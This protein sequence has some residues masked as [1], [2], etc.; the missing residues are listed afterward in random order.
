MSNIEQQ[1]LNILREL[2]QQ[3]DTYDNR[4]GE[5]TFKL[6]P[7]MIQHDMSEGFP[8][9]TTKRVAW[10]TMKVELEGFIK[11]I[12][13]KS[14]YQDRGCKI[15]NQWCNP[16]KVP[17]STDPKVQEIMAAEDDLGKIYGHQWRNYNDSGIDQLKN[18][19]YTLKAN[20]NDR[21][22][23][24]MAWNPQHLGEMALPP[25]HY[26]FQITTRGNKVDLTWN[27]RS[28]DWFLGATFNI[29]SYALLLSLIAKDA[30]MEAG[31][32]TGFFVDVHLYNNHIM[33][34]EEQLTREI[35]DS[36]TVKT[37]KFTNI[38]DWKYDDTDIVNYRYH[39]P[40]KAPVAI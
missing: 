3:A 13:S 6:P 19:L 33:A 16:Q 21:R 35:Y 31:L 29:A 38:F 39:P 34:A 2:T 22:M 24:C 4:T 14:W 36:P 15:W 26:S 10:K 17:Y 5:P 40:I 28:V 7:K 25:C 8:L 18:I 11:G 1:Y 30:N 23:I 12:T 20:P 32:L 27:Q 37:D 9:L